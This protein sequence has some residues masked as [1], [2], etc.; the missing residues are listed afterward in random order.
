MRYG[1]TIAQRAPH[2]NND[3]C[4]IGE[5]PYGTAQVRLDQEVIPAID[6]AA[7]EGS[8]PVRLP[9]DPASQTV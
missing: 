1:S 6:Q 8:R 7:L 3:I 2:A 4:V 9:L 5:P